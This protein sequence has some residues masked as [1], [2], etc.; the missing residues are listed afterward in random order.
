MKIDDAG[1]AFEAYFYRQ[2]LSQTNLG[3]S[4]FGGGGSASAFADMFT[5]AL[6]DQM[7]AS[8]DLGMGSMLAGA[9]QQGMPLAVR[10]VDGSI[11]SPFGLRSDP[12]DAAHRHHDGIDIAAHEGTPV[13]A[14]ADGVVVGVEERAGG[15][16]RLV[17]IDHGRGL[18]TRYA[19]LSDM[20]VAQGDR[21]RAG[22]AIGH[23]GQSG[24]ATGAHLHFEARS[25][26][27]P[28]NPES[29]LPPSR[30]GR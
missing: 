24:R 26:N 7:A 23:V 25:E 6:A 5:E 11:S 3:R 27:Q 2:L 20:S 18:T 10:P 29:V 16:G 13:R 30:K 22:D 21:V 9:S 1:R 19:H 12:I 4:V 14:A 28:L 15:Y 17:V 8:G